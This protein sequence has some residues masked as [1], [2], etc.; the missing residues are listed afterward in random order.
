MLKTSFVIG[1][2]TWARWWAHN[3]A[4][5][6]GSLGKLNGFVARVAI[7]LLVDACIFQLIVRVNTFTI[8]GLLPEHHHI[9]ESVRI[10]LDLGFRDALSFQRLLP[11]WRQSLREAWSAMIFKEI[12]LTFILWSKHIQE[13]QESGKL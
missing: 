2:E 9:V 7:A 6:I 8:V 12:D 10:L 1:R 5:C 11:F 13:N 3:L 4:T